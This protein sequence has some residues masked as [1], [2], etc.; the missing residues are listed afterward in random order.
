M[1]PIPEQRLDPIEEALC[2]ECGEAYATKG[3]LCQY[4]LDMERAE[5]DDDLSFEQSE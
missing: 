3:T 5:S 1:T 2:V 4:C